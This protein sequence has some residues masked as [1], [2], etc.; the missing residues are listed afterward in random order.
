MAINTLLAAG[1]IVTGILGNS[2]ALIADGIE[3]TADV[4]GSLIV[5]SGLRIA[6]KPADADHPYGHGKAES[7]AALIV[8]VMLLGAAALIAAQSI[9]EIR[10]PQHT[11]AWYTLIVLIC[12]VAIKETL[13][14]RAFRVGSHLESTALKSD[15]W[16]H[17]S[18][19]LT[20]AAAFIGISIALIGGRGFESADDWAALAACA[21]IV[22]N[23]LR[24]T[25]GA[26]DEIMDASATPE[27]V[28]L[29]RSIA[30]EVDGVEEVEKC[31]IRKIGLHLAMDIHVRVDGDLSVRRGHEIAHHVKDRLLASQHRINDVTVH[32]EPSSVSSKETRTESGTGNGGIAHERQDTSKS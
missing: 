5:W 13:A 2:S 19:A 24:L 12:V 21:V 25:R 26:L 14:R 8:S 28:D 16:H 29:I 27:I 7:I 1:K 20:S 11:P 15:A 23:G 31:R 30:S 10:T 3:S 9:H 22:F 17:R 18:D 32:I 6:A 4:F